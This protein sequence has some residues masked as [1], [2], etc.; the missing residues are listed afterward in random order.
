MRARAGLAATLNALGEVDA[1]ISHYRDM[2]KRNPGDNQGIRYVLAACLMKHGDT[3]ALKR[4]LEQ[5]D[6]DGSA[7]WLYTRALVG[8]REGDLEAEELAKKAWRRNNHVPA[9]LAGTKGEAI[10]ER[11]C[12]HGRRGRCG[13]LLR[14]MGLRLAHHARC[15]RL[16]YESCG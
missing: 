14:A 5:Y 8:F 12:H 4:L 15:D 2:L 13:R 3:E 7:P 9:V 11:L 6:E 10:D 1:A 16:A